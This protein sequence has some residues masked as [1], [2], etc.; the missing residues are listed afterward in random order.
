MHGFHGGNGGG[1]GYP[2]V[3]VVANAEDGGGDKDVPGGGDNAGERRSGAGVVHVPDDAQ[4]RLAVPAAP[5]QHLPL[6]LQARRLSDAVVLPLRQLR[7][8]RL[9][10]GLFRAVQV[11]QVL[12]EH[13]QAPF[14]LPQ[15][16]RTLG[17]AE[18]LHAP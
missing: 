5:Q 9:F 8:P 4:G 17:K 2:H 1:V 12:L 11:H 6:Q 15:R 3:F 16:H 7:Q 18:A 10:L 13:Q 14:A